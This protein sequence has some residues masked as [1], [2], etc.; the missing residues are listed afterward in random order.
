VIRV[1]GYRSR[2]PSSIPG[3]TRYSEKQWVWNGVHSASMSTIEELLGRKG[4][5]SGQEN[6]EYGRRDPLRWLRD[7]PLPTKFGTNLPNKPRSLGRYSLLADS[8]HGVFFVWVPRVLE[9]EKYVEPVPVSFYLSFFLSFFLSSKVV[10]C[11]IC[12]LIMCTFFN[13]FVFNYLLIF[14]S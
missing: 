2:G 4:S 1:P 14:H 10:H 7:T 13:I 12:L 9:T 3:A 8:G 6:R 11:I 5:G